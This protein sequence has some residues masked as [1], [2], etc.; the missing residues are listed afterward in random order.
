MTDVQKSAT[1]TPGAE[2]PGGGRQDH[3]V[4]REAAMRPIAAAGSTGTLAAIGAIDLPGR[5]AHPE[6]ARRAP[7]SSHGGDAPGAAAAHEIIPGE[8]DATTLTRREPGAVSGQFAGADIPAEGP[9]GWMD[10][11]TTHDRELE[12][13]GDR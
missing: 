3:D 4:M 13:G 1:D 10:D 6:L 7:G 11:A 12:G 9:R 5:E 8:R 2:P